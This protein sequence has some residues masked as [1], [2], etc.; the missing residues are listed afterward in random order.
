M[1][2]QLLVALAP[3]APLPAQ[4]TCPWC[5]E[6][7]AL[8][9]AAGV[10]SHGPIDIGPP[11][12][13][14][15]PGSASIEAELAAS[16]WLFI[17]TEHLRW[18]AVL[19]DEVVQRRD[20]EHVLAELARLREVLP[21]VPEKPKVIDR[22][23]RLHLYAMR[24][25]ELYARFQELLRVSDE[26]FPESRQAEG[27]F[28]GDGR[29]L[30]EKDKFE[31]VLHAN[32]RS[33]QD[34]TRKMCGV[35]VTGTLCHHIKPAHKMIASIPMEDSDRKR[36]RDLWPHVG[37]SL[38]HLFLRAYKHFSYEPPLW[39]DEGLA[40]MI[41]KEIHP[42]STTIDGEE[43]LD[44]NV[45]VPKDW[46]VAARKSA[47]DVERSSF[48]RLLHAKSFGELDMPLQVVAWSRVRFLAD[49]H[50][51]GFAAFLGGVKGQLDE[52]GYPD[53][54]DLPGLQRE[55]LR[56]VFGWTP[57]QFDRAWAEW[58]AVKR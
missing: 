33:H 17:E 43:G 47:R 39:L 14:G 36:D 41:E 26:D 37:H 13:G 16:Q 40:H 55:L 31:V 2:L 6:E 9:A 3:G 50:P 18:A 21:D 58:A 25:E 5:K 52:R 49:E 34:F 29:F 15:E 54:G 27:P 32:L 48:A 51:E 20:K 23:L 35:S 57:A 7:P 28:M 45:K 12:E 24:G 8:M 44:S 56:E 19:A 42:P 46:W 53:G 1:L 30:G 4:E 22:W 11:G 10:L 38:S